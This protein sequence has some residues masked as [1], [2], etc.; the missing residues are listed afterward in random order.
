MSA[1]V[2]PFCDFIPI[3]DYAIDRLESNIS[4]AEDILNNYFFKRILI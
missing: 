1:N 3:Y 4:R 2:I